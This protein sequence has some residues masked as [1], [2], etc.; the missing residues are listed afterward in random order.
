[1]KN[2]LDKGEKTENRNKILILVA[3]SI[4]FFVFFNLVASQILQ[5]SISKDKFDADE[6]K[7]TLKNETGEVAN[8]TLLTPIAYN[9]IRGKDR[10]VAC[11]QIDNQL[12]GYQN[13]FEKVDFYNLKDNNAPI[14]KDFKYKY[15]V[16]TGEEEIPLYET[17][18]KTDKDGNEHCKQTEKGKETEPKFE[19][20]VFNNSSALPK[21]ITEICL[22]A[23]V[24][25][26]ENIEWQPRS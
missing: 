5:N 20:V 2:I 15:K 25:A 13:L 23:D 17:V 7:I 9:V 12:E 11:L 18:C 10:K 6:K 16:Q 4:G 22:S 8:I 21:G 24:E 19:Y 3:L 1:M 26:G 14:Q